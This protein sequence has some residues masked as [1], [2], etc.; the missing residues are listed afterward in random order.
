MNVTSF[1]RFPKLDISSSI[2]HPLSRGILTRMNYQ[3]CAGLIP[4]TFI[5]EVRSRG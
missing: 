4:Q 1:S 3:F 2:S 5:M